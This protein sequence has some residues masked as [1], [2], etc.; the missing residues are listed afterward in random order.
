AVMEM[1]ASGQALMHHTDD[2]MEGVAA[3]IEKRDA[4][5]HGK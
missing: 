5:F 2:H 4:T 1:S 3:V